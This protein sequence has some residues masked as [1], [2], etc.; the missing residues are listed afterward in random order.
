MIRPAPLL[1]V[2]RCPT[3]PELW[4]AYSVAPFG[5]VGPRCTDFVPS[6]QAAEALARTLGDLAEPFDE[7]T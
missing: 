2:L 4:A 5:G 1:A 3:D 6:P 7:A